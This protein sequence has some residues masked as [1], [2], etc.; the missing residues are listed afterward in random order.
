METELH[1]LSG[2]RETTINAHGGQSLRYLF[3]RRV[4]LN[5]SMKTHGIL[6]P[7]TPPFALKGKVLD[8]AAVRNF[9]TRS[10]EQVTVTL[11]NLE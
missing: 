3:A 8:H 6:C 5:N 11:N 10:V 4:V 1:A 2:L 7:A 9:K